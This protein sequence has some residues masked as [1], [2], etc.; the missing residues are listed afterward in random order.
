MKARL[1]G[2][3]SLPVAALAITAEIVH[4]QIVHISAATWIPT[5]AMLYAKY[6]TAAP[7]PLRLVMAGG[8]MILFSFVARMVARKGSIAT[9]QI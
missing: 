5:L 1:T 2:F 4:T 8:G 3:L 6:V 7:E 9:T